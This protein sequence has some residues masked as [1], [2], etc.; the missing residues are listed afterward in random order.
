MDSKYIHS[1][2]C[3]DLHLEEISDE[4]EIHKILSQRNL[5]ISPG[6]CDFPQV[7]YKKEQ[8][9]RTK[10]PTS[11]LTIN[12]LHC[13]IRCCDKTL[14]RSARTLHVQEVILCC[15]LLTTEGSSIATSF[16]LDIRHSL[17]KF[18]TNSRDEW[19]WM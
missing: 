19:R 6:T 18:H 8:R 11:C 2:I 17:L 1:H 15:L 9:S 4:V 7:N 5:P 12:T 16:M 14:I 3:P 13:I 10:E